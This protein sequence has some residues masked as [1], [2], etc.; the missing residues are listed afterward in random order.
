MYVLNSF[1][2]LPSEQSRRM[3]WN[4][5]KTC[6]RS[7]FPLTLAAFTFEKKLWFA[8]PRL[9]RPRCYQKQGSVL[10][11][12]HDTTLSTTVTSNKGKL[13]Q[14]SL[15]IFSD[16]S[17]EHNY[18]YI[19]QVSEQRKHKAQILGWQITSR[20]TWKVTDVWNP[21]REK[22]YCRRTDSFCFCIKGGVIE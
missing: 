20:Y 3:L 18:I 10:K 7:N 9:A 12:K 21:L 22:L 16:L 4:C 6:L 1:L 14:V 2:Y 19:L 13:F 15:K 5:T 8:T 17:G 11:R